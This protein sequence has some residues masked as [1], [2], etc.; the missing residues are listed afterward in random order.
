MGRS[1]IVTVSLLALALA[2]IAAACAMRGPDAVKQHLWWSGL[3]PVLPHDTFPADCRTCHVGSDWQSLT[4]D[5]TF[6]HAAQT[7]VPLDGAHARASCILCHNDRGPAGVFNRQGCAGCH[8]DVHE[9]DLGVACKDCHQQ[10]TWRALDQRA[11]HAHTRFPL[12]GVHASTACQR[13]HPGAEVGR[14]VPTDPECVSCHASDLART[15]NP[16]HFGLGWTDRCDR[17]HLPRTWNQAE[18]NP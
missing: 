2:W 17:C 7:G 11:G 10:T 9:G 18:N 6:D 13:C 12:L 15:N 3:G 8:E 16:D 14:F 5:F 4:E 1:K